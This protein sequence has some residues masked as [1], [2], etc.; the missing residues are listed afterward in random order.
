[1]LLDEVADALLEAG[2]QRFEEADRVLDDVPHQIRDPLQDAEQQ[3]GQ[4]EDGLADGL[5]EFD[6]AIEPGL[7]E[8]FVDVVERRLAAD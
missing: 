1:M 6:G 8:L 2:D 4:L 7:P 5:D 3:L